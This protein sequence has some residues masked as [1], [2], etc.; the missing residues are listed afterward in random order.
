[1]ARAARPGC[2]SAAAERAGGVALNRRAVGLG[3]PQVLVALKLDG[4]PLRTNGRHQ[5][6]LLGGQRGDDEEGRAQRRAAQGAEDGPC[7]HGVGPIVERQL[8]RAC[9]RA[10]H[11]ECGFPNKPV[12]Q[13]P[14]AGQPSRSRATRAGHER[15]CGASAG[16]AR[17]A[18]VRPVYALR[19]AIP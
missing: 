5:L 13:A 6:G 2:A 7:P 8:D 14:V 18:P 4:V 10:S 9:E 17:T 11:W 1:M 3:V 12:A 19:K 15:M 16:H